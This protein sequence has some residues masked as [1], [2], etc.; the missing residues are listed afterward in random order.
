MLVRVLRNVEFDHMDE[1][2]AAIDVENPSEFIR[3]LKEVDFITTSQE[4]SLMNF[5]K[6]ELYIP[7]F[8]EKHEGKIPCINVYIMHA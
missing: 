8:E 1:L 3:T 4:D 5:Y 2:L 7:N 6:T